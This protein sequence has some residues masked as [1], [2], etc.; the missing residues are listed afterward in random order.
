VGLKT[1]GYFLTV[2]LGL[3]GS[4]SAASV[5]AV[6]T[7]S[8]SAPATSTAAAPSSATAMAQAASAAPATF[9][10]APANKVNYLFFD[11]GFGD[12]PVPVSLRALMGQRGVGAKDNF[13]TL[14]LGAGVYEKVDF[15]P[16][17]LGVQLE[18][19]EDSYSTYLGHQLMVCQGYLAF[20][21]IQYFG[22]EPGHGYFLRADIGEILAYLDDSQT[23]NNPFDFHGLRLQGGFGYAMPLDRLRRFSLLGMV[24]NIVETDN[25]GTFEGVG[26]ELRV[27]LLF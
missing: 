13:W 22:T 19:F 25:S 24:N 17:L 4:A 27:A 12:Q 7:V 3:A 9:T 16:Y 11:Q 18:F 26:N 20:S 15:A 8:F 21:G 1:L 5:N 6:D 2:L 10:A 23:R 14:N